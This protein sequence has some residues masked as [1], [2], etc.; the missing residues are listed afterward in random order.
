MSN[1]SHGD[2]FLYG[3]VACFVLVFLGGIVSAMIISWGW[4]TLLVPPAIAMAVGT[5]YGLGWGWDAY[6][7]YRHQQMHR[8]W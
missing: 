7:K 1:V 6:L 5:V 2:R 3:L 4:W 8:T